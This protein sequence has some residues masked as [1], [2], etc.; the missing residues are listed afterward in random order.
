MDVLLVV[1]H[2][3]TAGQRRHPQ[4]SARGLGLVL[5]QLETVPPKNLEVCFS[6][7]L[8]RGRQLQRVRVHQG[9]PLNAALPVQ[10]LEA[11]L[12]IRGV[13]VHDEE[14]QVWGAADLQRSDDEAQV[15]LANDPHLGEA[16]LVEPEAPVKLG[17][18][19]DGG[20]CSSQ[21]R[22]RE[23]PWNVHA[24]VRGL[25]S[26]GL[27]AGPQSFQGHGALEAA[28]QRWQADRLCVIRRRAWRHLRLVFLDAKVHLLS[29]R[30]LRPVFLD[31]KVHL[32]S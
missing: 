30:H 15:E 7:L 17:H 28:P 18:L 22:Q 2:T 25:R 31:A 11:E 29:W 12:L 8:L 10:G 3:L 27:L 26:F 4:A 21:R 9:L 19:L 13:L 24:L 23:G 16:A 5:Q 1:D 20:A 14:L 32:L 6:Q